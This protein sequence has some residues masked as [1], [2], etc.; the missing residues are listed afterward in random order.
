MT[1]KQQ[2][3]VFGR[4]PTFNDVEVEGSLTLGGSAIPAPA[5]T[6]TSSDIGVTVQ[7]YDA[8]TAKLDVSQSFSAE[9]KFN[10]GAVFNEDGNDVDFRIESDI[11]P[12][13]FFLDGENGNVRIGT[14]LR[15]TGLSNF[16]ICSV[17]PTIKFK[18]GSVAS[19]DD[20]LA[21]ITVFSADGGTGLFDNRYGSSIKFKAEG[22]SNT[23][24]QPTYISFET[25]DSGAS[26]NILERVRITSSG[27]VDLKTGNLIIGTSGKGIDFSAT[28]GTGTSEL[29]D[30]YE[31]GTFTPTLYGN[32]TAGTYELATASGTY[33]KV[34]RVV[35]AQVLLVLAGSV[36]G[37]GS[38]DTV[39]G[40]LPFTYDG[41]E[42]PGQHSAVAS[43]G[44][45]FAAGATVTASRITS[46]DDTR[47][48]LYE[49]VAGTSIATVPITDFGAND[50]VSFTVT[51]FSI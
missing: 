7:G 5:D 48:T 10:N 45:S 27:N 34:G 25:N 19:A 42:N 18:N 39:I 46:S 4:N 6:L 22:S 11:D 40:G 2:G 20:T 29:F 43:G 41:S 23:Y 14:P 50:L 28:S 13:A 9:Q 31:E 44:I 47:L 3:G 37:G 33:T 26:S 49:S 24:H 30:D 12:Y 15:D 1:I 16:N 32:A 21:E 51:Y 35:T 17:A 8:D 38:G 36:T